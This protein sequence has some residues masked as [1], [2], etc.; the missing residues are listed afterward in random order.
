MPVP[1]ELTATVLDRRK[2]SFQLRWPAP[3]TTGGGRVAGYDIRVAKAAIT[4]TNF[5]ATTG[6]MT[7]AYSG[8]PA[9]PGTADGVVVSGLNI[10]QDYYFAV[11]GKDAA[12]TRGTIMATSTA[13]AATF[14]TT[15]LSG[16]GTDGIGID[17][18]G[19]GDFGGGSTRSFTADGFSDLIVGGTGGV[20]VYVYFGSAG[21][22]S[23]TP[24]ITITGSVTNFGV[25]VANAGDLDGDGLDDIA[26]ASPGD[27]N[28]KVFIFSRKNPPASWGVT[29]AWP[30]TLMD[31]Q[32]NYTLTADT[33]FAGGVNSIFRRAMARLGNFDGTGVSDLA[34]GFRLHGS[35]LGAVVIVKGST[36]FA[37][38]TI[39]DPAGTSTI[40][41][42]GMTASGQLGI[43]LLGAGPFFASP[44]GPALIVSAP[45]AS[46]VYAFR[47]QAPAGT[48]TTANADDS[49]VGTPTTDQYGI[50]LGFLGPLGGSPGALT[51]ASTMGK[52]VDVHLG[53]VAT[54]P[55]LGAAGGAPSASVRFVDAQSGNSFGVVN[56]GGGIRG[57]SS[58]ASFIGG[59][60]IPDLVMG[61]QAETGLPLYIVSG[62]A[63][64]T[65]SGMVDV[66]T[67]QTAVVPPIVKVA[68][69]LP[70]PWSGHASTT[71]IPDSNK[72]GY[73]DF[74]VGES[75]FGAAGR[76][77][78]LY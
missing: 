68:N 11:A 31:T 59:D 3:S 41:I 56:L 25:A 16:T 4:A 66:S 50:N 54:G 7:V 22:Y 15:V 28:G 9:A 78:V 75:A 1:T 40:E 20:H 60:S 5:D 49:V 71:V 70:S 43:S 74:A 34:I 21:G 48:L 65:M 2:T 58:T 17:A 35:N 26:I 10:E 42:D 51:I 18:E 38:R 44:A 14:L 46:S 72:D 47:G 30:A 39:P 19:T 12:G 77:V 8:T 69:R 45:L 63:I 27:G 73:A 57:T 37:S 62:A 23:T 67:A 29:N 55:F 64:P 36:T 6:V 76:V 61:G 33:T 52:Y 13:V 24:S 32:A 53:T